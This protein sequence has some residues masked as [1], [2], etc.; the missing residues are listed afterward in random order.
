MDNAA[1]EKRTPKHYGSLRSQWN[2]TASQQFDVWLRG[3]AGFILP[4]SPF[5]NTVRVPGY[6]TLDLRY[7]YRIN[8]DLE[9]SVTGRNLIGTRRYEYV[10]D[11]VP[12][13]PIEIKPSLLVGMR[14]G[15]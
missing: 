9:L 4:N 14:L 3:S 8:K 1:Q 12:S 15:F 5:T 7:A 10:A 13:V 2:I 6:V 11:Y